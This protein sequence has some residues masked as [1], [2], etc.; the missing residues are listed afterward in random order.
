MEPFWPD[1]ALPARGPYMQCIL[2]LAAAE[3][4]T[5]AVAAVHVCLQTPGCS[6][7]WTSTLLLLRWYADVALAVGLQL[8]PPGRLRFLVASDSPLAV[9]DFTAAVTATLSRDFPT[10]SGE[11]LRASRFV[12]WHP[13]PVIPSCGTAQ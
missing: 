1:A 2:Q 13:G 9:A 3:L 8:A 7:D 12:F 4:T 11:L 5:M 10:G 6:R